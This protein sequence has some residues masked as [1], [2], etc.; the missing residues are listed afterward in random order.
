MI[1]TKRKPKTLAHVKK[2]ST[3]LAI[4][5]RD[6]R[7]QERA[8][9]SEVNMEIWFKRNGKCVTCLAGSVMRFSLGCNRGGE[10]VCPIDLKT[11][12]WSRSALN[13]LN[14][15]RDGYVRLAAEEMG[16]LTTACN[17][18]VPDYDGPNG[19]W[20]AAMRQL[21]KDLKAAHE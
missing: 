19:E 20:W 10:E 8:P 13:A 5:L 3:L 2:L 12:Q 16:M 21:L 11:D 14:D 7:K 9:D 4:G 1:K 15:L 18:Y 17:R 6:L